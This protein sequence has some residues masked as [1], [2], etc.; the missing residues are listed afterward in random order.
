M[1]ESTTFVLI[2]LVLLAVFVALAV[3]RV[4][5][6]RDLDAALATIRALDIE[7]FRN[8]VNPE[9]EEFLR[10]NLSAAEFRAVKRERTL[11]ALAYVSSLADVSLQFARFG[12]AAQ[13]NPDPA[14]AALGRQIATSGTYLRLRAL[15]ARARLTLS[16]A[17]P[18]LPSRPLRSL[19]DQYDHASRLLINHNAISRV[20]SRAS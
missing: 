4:H 19:L 2:A 10:T 5:E 20:E 3:R 1:S 7:A 9:E 14:L 6:S 16:L 18:A 17:F 15:D 8:L 13:Q 11:A 12:G